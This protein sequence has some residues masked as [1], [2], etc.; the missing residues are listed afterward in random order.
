MVQA[1]FRLSDQ[2]E[3]PPEQTGLRQEQDVALWQA[4]N[5]LDDRRRETVI[6]VEPS[7]LPL[8]TP[9]PYPIPASCPVT[10]PN[11]NTPPGQSP[12]PTYHG[13]GQL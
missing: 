4:I 1:L 6:Q 9:T 7:P 10:L 13:N 5:A 3:P 2:T 8:P 11:G 12:S